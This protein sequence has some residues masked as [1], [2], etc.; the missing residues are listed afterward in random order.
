MINCSQY[1]EGYASPK[2][3]R[4]KIELSPFGEEH[5]AYFCRQCKEPLCV[6]SCRVK[7]IKFKPRLK[8]YEIDYKLCNN[9]QKCLDACP[10]KAIFIDPVK[11]R[12]IKCN[13]CKGR[14]ICVKSCYTQ[15]LSFN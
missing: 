11:N 10:F 4:L 14:F 12:I 2:S 9:C 15:A 3:A 1:Q 7:A 13:T 6:K 8:I 5:T